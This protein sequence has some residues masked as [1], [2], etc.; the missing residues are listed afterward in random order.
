[1]PCPTATFL[2]LGLISYDVLLAFYL[3]TVFSLGLALTLMLVGFAALLSNRFAD[4]IMGDAGH[5]GSGNRWMTQIL[6]ALSSVAVVTIGGLMV[7][8]YLYWIRM[9]RALVAWLG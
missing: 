5:H 3:V 8:N 4:R 9:G 6:P 1:M 2:G 7:A